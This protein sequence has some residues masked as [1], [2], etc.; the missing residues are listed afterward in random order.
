M[1]VLVV[2]VAGDTVV[3]VVVNDGVNAVAAL[4]AVVVRVGDGDIV[5]VVVL[6][7]GGGVVFLL[8]TP[9]GKIFFV[10]IYFFSPPTQLATK[11]PAWG[12]FYKSF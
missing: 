7:G 8:L 4:V 10:Q 6:G 11:N 2:I 1:M 5:G 9:S 3:G 12:Q